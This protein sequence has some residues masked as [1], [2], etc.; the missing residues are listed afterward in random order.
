MGVFTGQKKEGRAGIFEEADGGTLFLDE[1]GDAAP[2]LQQML[3]RVLQ[4]KEVTRVGAT[5]PT[6]VDVRVIGAT[7]RDLRRRCREGAFRWDLYHRL[8]LAELRVPPLRDRGLG[9]TKVRPSWWSLR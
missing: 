6:S 9:E 3:L 7:H 4:E 8:S 1:I 2:E 5:A